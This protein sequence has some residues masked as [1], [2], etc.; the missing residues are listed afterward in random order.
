MRVRLGPVVQR[1]FYKYWVNQQDTISHGSIGVG[2]ASLTGSDAAPLFENSQDK[3]IV[4]V[5]RSESA[6]C[7]VIS[8]LHWNDVLARTS[9]DTRLVIHNLDKN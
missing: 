1:V 7:T 3:T 9:D 4:V 2:R 8:A 6:D 5:P